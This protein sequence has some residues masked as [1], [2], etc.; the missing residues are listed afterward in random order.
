MNSATFHFLLGILAIGSVTQTH[1]ACVEHSFISTQVEQMRSVLDSEGKQVSTYIEKVSKAT[2][3]TQA[4]LVMHAVQMNKNE[5]LF[6]MIQNQYTTKFKSAHIQP[7]HYAAENGNLVAIK[8][9]LSDG[10]HGHISLRTS[11]NSTALHYAAVGNHEAV[12]SFLLE[13]NAPVN[14]QD[15]LGNTPLHY[16]IA[17]DHLPCVYLLLAHGANMRIANNN[18]ETPLYLVKALKSQHASSN[19]VMPSTPT[20]AAPVSPEPENEILVLETSE[21]LSRSS[22]QSPGL[23]ESEQVTYKVDRNQIII[24]SD[25]QM[26]TLVR[27][28]TDFAEQL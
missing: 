21:V 24:P 23:A 4:T 5:H 7:L 3:F 8:L 15:S 9:L 26:E 12:V 17:F 22:S 1:A 18:G 11:Q 27:S 2:P 25:D 28:L 20:P 10:R 14:A 16:A 19:M 13:S 6:T